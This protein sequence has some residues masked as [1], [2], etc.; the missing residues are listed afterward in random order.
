MAESGHETDYK[1]AVEASVIEVGNNEDPEQGGYNGK[2]HTL[3]FKMPFDQ[4][5]VYDITQR[6]N[7]C[8]NNMNDGKAYFYGYT[9]EA[10][11]RSLSVDFYSALT[12]KSS[13]YIT[14]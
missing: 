10:N 13:I 9:D 12:P 11:V 14:Y 5:K 6:P 1:G 8:A 2:Y 7:L 4:N 3:Y